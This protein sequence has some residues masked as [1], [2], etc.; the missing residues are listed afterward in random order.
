MRD[1][2]AQ[3]FWLAALA[4]LVAAAALAVWSGSRRTIAAVAVTG[5]AGATLVSWTALM[6]VVF[7]ESGAASLPW[8]VIGGRPFVLA[9]RLDPLAALILALATTVALAVFVYAARYLWDEPRYRRFFALMSLFVGA[10]L[11]LVIADDLILLFGAWEVVGL[12]SYLLIGLWFERPG[13]PRAA[14]QA[15]LVTR[16]ADAA[17]L[18]GLLI[19]AAATGSG[20]LSGVMEALS[21][22]RLQGAVVT[23]ASLLILTG[24]MGKS[25]QLPL[26]GWL[27]DAMLGPTPVSALIH[28]ATMVAAGVYLVARFLPL[29]GAGGTLP[30]VAWVGAATALFGAGA[31]LG[32]TDLKRLL[33][34]STMSQLGFMFIALGAGSVSAGILLLVGQGV[35]KALLFLAAGSVSHAVGTTDMR[36]LGGLRLRMPV[37]FALFTLGAAALAGIPVSLA[38]PFK[39]AAL[40]AALYASVPLAAVAFA[41]ALLTALYSTRAVTLTFLGMPR[42]DKASGAR[43]SGW[44]LLAPMVGLGALLVLASLLGSWLVD[45]PI[46]RLLGRP[47][48]ESAGA[49]ILAFVT[50]AAGVGLAALAYRVW[51]GASTWPP[52]R[53]LA[54]AAEAGLGIPKAY[55]AVAGTTILVAR[56]ARTLDESAFDT[57]GVRMA[58]AARSVALLARRLDAAVF[59]RVGPW[60]AQ[61]ARV[62]AVHA[63]RVDQGVFDAASDALARGTLDVVRASL[64]FDLGR[65]DAAFDAGAIAIGRFGQHLRAMQTGRIDNYLFAIVLW[66]VGALAAGAAVLALRS[67]R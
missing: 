6:A 25:A 19:L 37:T 1:W 66:G 49:T 18:A 46:A 39:D 4:P 62:L 65:L 48:P 33:A 54:P 41:A 28:S 9:A 35:F 15:F 27:P 57:I 2:P 30:L 16:V 64:C 40:A 7:G 12:C 58:G 67:V 23:I 52:F 11:T 42:G 53:R 44:W 32:Q 26:N 5:V 17:L 13:V 56:Y 38:L 31:A 29:F 55:G 22:G 21:Q 50:T 61:T 36:Q 8:L 43:E 14:T 59:E 3:Y 34:Y 47:L 45:L 10:M 24:A 63:R 60:I 51:P 20:S